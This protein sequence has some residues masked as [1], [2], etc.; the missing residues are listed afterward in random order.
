MLPVG[1]PPPVFIPPTPQTTVLLP[2][3]MAADDTLDI[4]SVVKG[5]T[6][7]TKRP[8]RMSADVWELF[9]ELVEGGGT[10]DLTEE[11]AS[12]SEVEN[13]V[14]NSQMAP[15]DKARL[16]AQVVNRR[17]VSKREQMRMLEKR[18]DF[19]DYETFG[20]FLDELSAALHKHIKDPLVIKAIGKD[21]VGA[22]NMIKKRARGA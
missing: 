22:L 4:M 8:K 17:V 18:R 7:P 12:L 1:A 15:E 19:I 13:Y 3:V 6:K 20:T 2:V 10:L 16:I 14:R 11:I 9:Q 5:G 21:M